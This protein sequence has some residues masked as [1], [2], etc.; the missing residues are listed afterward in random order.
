MKLL[1]LIEALDEKRTCG[2]TEREIRK[3]VY[4]S[5][6]AEPGSLF[7]AIP[8]TKLDGHRFINSAIT[9]GA[10]G[11]VSERP[12][13]FEKIP[14][15]QVPDSRKALA[16]LAARFYDY[17]A[18]KL[19]IIGV[20]GTNG[21]TTTSHM[22]A[23]ILEQNDIKTGIIGT[24]YAKIGDEKLD[25][26]ITTPE[27]LEIQQYLSRMTEAGLEAAVMEVSSHALH[28]DRIFGIEFDG[29]VFTN[30]SQDHLDFHGDFE[31]YFNEKKKLFT[32]IKPSH[33]GGFALVNSDDPRAPEIVETLTVPYKSFG[34]YRKPDI[35]AKKIRKSVY[36]TSF[37][38]ESDRWDIPIKLKMVGEFNIYNAL[39]AVGVGLF[40]DVPPVNIYRGLESLSGVRGRFEI[41][42]EGQPFG[43]VV[44][45]AHTPDGLENV[46]K[47]AR[48]ITLN[49]LIVV[50]GCGGDRDRKKRPIMGEIAGEYGDLVIVT[51][52]NPRTE[53]P[54][55]IIAEIQ[56]G[57]E[58]NT[59]DYE[60]EVDRRTA[61]Q[62][63]ISMAERGDLI[64][65]AGKGHETY[66]I[67]KNRTIHF[68]DAEEAR[69]AIR[70][71]YEDLE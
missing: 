22:I 38:A 54:R 53:D 33:R 52:D 10:V 14:V 45:Y 60:V 27:S 5:R 25:T 6:Q 26:R 23:S 12:V 69:K 1:D 13:S 56:P 49:R 8:G 16:Q 65:I 39:A 35:R 4:D 41:I 29:A 15:I 68:D 18:R 42:D 24:L 19:K 50:F 63:A 67:F 36:G 70:A 71:Q 51:S 28:F 17:P 34:I 47:A 30:I 32:R 46:L 55:K 58:K 21:K 59:K 43:V 57:V 48:D 40:W 62:K 31:T 64:V 9:R 37:V 3:I 2:E 7:V 11:V 66:Q 44:D 61:I 20:T